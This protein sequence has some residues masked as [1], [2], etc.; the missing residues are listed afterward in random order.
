MSE[1]SLHEITKKFGTNPAIE[2]LSI[3]IGPGEI[4]GVTGPSG[5]GKSTVCRMIAGLESPSSG[6][7]RFDGRPVNTLPP[8]ARNT[9]FMFESYA[10][11]PHYTVFENISFPLL[12]PGN[13]R[14]YSAAQIKERVSELVR[15]VEIEGLEQRL[16][17]ELSGGQ[18]QRVALCRALIQEPSVYLLDEPISHLDAKLNHKLRGE[19]RRRII[20]KDVPTLWTSPNGIEILSVADRAVVLVGGRVQQIDTPREIFRHPATIEVA[21]LIGD[22]PMNLLAGCLG[23]DRGGLWFRHPAFALLL[24][25]PLRKRLESTSA[26]RQIIVGV[27]PSGIHLVDDSG[28]KEGVPGEIYVCE[29]LGKCSIVSVRIG[30]DLIKV[31]TDGYMDYRS[32]QLVR[33]HFRGSEVMAFDQASG[34]VI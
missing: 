34:R 1:I 9:A 21:R 29:P 19:I 16:P 12:S 15:L 20:N 22:P 25:E 18:K 24:E 28:T 8:Q 27:R 6:E 33:L 3:A 10:L 11:Y 23:D 2:N 14:R 30:N 26:Q 32:G 5:A 17:A 4:L 13:R 31:K 7:V